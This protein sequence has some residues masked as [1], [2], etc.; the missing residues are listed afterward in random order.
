MTTS[1]SDLSR[2]LISRANDTVAISGE[3]LDV[4]GL[5]AV[6]RA[7]AVVAPLDDEGRAR[8]SRSRDWV[9][10]AAGRGDET[11][12][13]VNT[14]FG[15]LANTR[16]SVDQQSTLS[17]NVILKCLVGVDAALPEDW[18]RAMLLV[19]ANSLAR[20]VSGVRPVIIDTLVEMLNR[21]V[22]PRIPSKGSLGASGDLA[23]LAHLAAVATRGPD[24]MTEDS[25]GEAWVDG[26]L[27]SGEEAMAAAGIER[28]IVEAKEG[29]AL[30][31]GT[32]MM[33]AGAALAVHDAKRALAHAE[34]A[35]ALMMEGL[36]ALTEAFQPDLHAA[37][38]Q[39][40]QIRTAARLRALMAGSRLVD[41]DP[42][43][44]QDAYSI[45]CTPQVLGPIH[46]MLGFLEGRISDGLNAASDNP[47]I[48]LDR[49]DHP[50]RKAVSGGNFHGAGPALWLDTLGI[51]IADAANISDRRVFRALTPE[52]SGGLPPMLIEDAGL[53]GGLM[54]VQYTGAALVSDNKTL[55]HPDSVD[56]IPSSAN[57]ED[58]VSMG[59]NAARHAHEIVRNVQHVIAI[60]FVS[61]AQAI[62][63]RPDGADRLG[64]GTAA[65]YAVLRERL[66]PVTA[67]R[68]LAP[69]IACVEDLIDS[70][71]LMRAAEEGLG[72]PLP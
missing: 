40:G 25:S 46:D 31:N 7:G 20:G 24:E 69:D 70:G 38:N 45:R 65:V 72:H 18:V 71:A 4:E 33:I 2:S 35:A 42:D 58:H 15:S 14:G 61:A 59:A 62:Y 12:Y 29:L 23:P 51:A 47:L 28:P 13:G 17:R 27:M 48:F 34:I 5:V 36:R 56:S 43:K 49:A 44:V 68:A 50:T 16:I 3:G 9:A 55:A 63:L 26:A 30:T 6:S 52:L 53:N 39:P 19:R 32:T 21:G 11:I 67:D 54:M 37:N 1:P 10:E 8:V 60:E 57:Q 64:A 66:R 41:S 22:V